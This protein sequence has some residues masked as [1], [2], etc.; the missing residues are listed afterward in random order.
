MNRRLRQIIRRRANAVCEYCKLPD[1]ADDFPFHVDHILAK[2]H[3]GDD[4][5]TN[6]SW[7]CT[8]C[9]LHK[10]T[11]FASVDPV[12][13]ERVN[14]YDPRVDSWHDHFLVSLDGRMAGITPCGRAT[15]QLLDMNGMPQLALRRSLI[16]Q[17]VYTL[18]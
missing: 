17:G 10:G 11:N 8:Q 1:A 7:T 5:D 15:V 13:R 9:N 12:S 4:S 14:L 6:L 3:G 2:I 18:D 16:K